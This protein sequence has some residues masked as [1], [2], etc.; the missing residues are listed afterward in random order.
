MFVAS[1]WRDAFVCI[2][3]SLIVAAVCA[4]RFA[5]CQLMVPAMVSAVSSSESTSVA[6]PANLL[7][8]ANP[9]CADV[10]VPDVRRLWYTSWMNGLRL[11]HV[12]SPM[13][14][15]SQSSRSHWYNPQR[16]RRSI[17]LIRSCWM[18]YG[19]LASVALSWASVHHLNS[20]LG[21]SCGLYDAKKLT[22]F[23]RI[24]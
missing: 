9:P 19:F 1:C 17:T 8:C 7:F 22:L 2:A 14:L 20:I 13:G 10:I 5:I 6:R 23:W 12:W 21:G 16:A 11:I 18:V 15:G 24:A 3:C 4:V